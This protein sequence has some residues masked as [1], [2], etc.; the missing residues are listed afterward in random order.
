MMADDTLPLSPHA[1]ATA[2][3]AVPAVEAEDGFLLLMLREFRQADA[4]PAFALM[5]QHL[6]RDA[7]RMGRHGV[8]FHLTFRPEVMAF[9]STIVGRPALHDAEGKAQRNPAWPFLAW[10]SGPR[11]WPSGEHT[12]EWWAKVSF[13]HA[14]AW[15]AFRARYAERLAG[16]LEAGA[17]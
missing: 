10:R 2:I 9:L 3:G 11:D 1:L 16:R 15:H 5:Q 8:S 7:H 13:P 12:V 4:P 14:A 6:L 17:A